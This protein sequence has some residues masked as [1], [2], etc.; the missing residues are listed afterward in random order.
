MTKSTQSNKKYGNDTRRKWGER[1]GAKH[2]QVPKPIGEE[3]K[4]ILRQN[5]K[6]IF[7][8]TSNNILK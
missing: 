6:R 7:L 3:E 4:R 2:L 5:N 8:R 1:E